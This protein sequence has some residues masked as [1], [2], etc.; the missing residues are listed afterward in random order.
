MLTGVLFG[1]A[2][3]FQSTRPDVAPTLKDQAG[4][5]LGG[6]ARL[7]KA[8]VASQMAVSLLLLIGAGLFIRT[9]DN[10]LAVDIGFDT[11]RLL[12][13]S[14]D[15]SLNGYEAA[16]DAEFA[17]TML[18]RLNHDAGHRRR[19]GSRACGCSKGTSGARA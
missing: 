10:L 9:L 4:N 2:P 1:L 17:K 11:S 12:S 13:F 19:A 3:A 14:M 6:Q 18:E 5:V 15:P 7:R 16:A 8:L